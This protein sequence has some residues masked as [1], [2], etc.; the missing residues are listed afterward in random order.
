MYGAFT[1]SCANGHIDVAK[2]LIQLS[3]YS[4]YD[5][6]DIHEHNDCPLLESCRNGHID[7]AKWLVQSVGL[8]DMDELADKFDIQAAFRLCCLNDNI[9]MAKWMVSLNDKGHY[10]MIYPD[11]KCIDY[12]NI[13]YKFDM[14]KWLIQLACDN[15][16]R[17]ISANMIHML[18]FCSITRG[19]IDY[20]KWLIQLGETHHFYKINQN[21]MLYDAFIRCCTNG[22][23]DA[24]KWLLQ[25]CETNDV[26]KISSEIIQEAFIRCCTNGK[27][28]VA[29]W[30]I[31]L[32]EMTP[33]YKFTIDER[34]KWLMIYKVE[35]NGH[36]E[37]LKW[38]CELYQVRIYLSNRTALIYGILIFGA[39]S[40]LIMRRV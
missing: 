23:I 18:F 29:K 27:I 6:I 12:Q 24:A 21:D 5:E 7:I 14:A 31:Q 32:G 35:S 16:Y 40:Y 2:W 19:H 10:P 11:D 9:E 13:G 4:G 38:L 39:L 34:K 22:K 20:A 37:I 25:L 3:K 1:G 30:L 26:C 28:D 17:N 36:G 33:D 15:E 8:V